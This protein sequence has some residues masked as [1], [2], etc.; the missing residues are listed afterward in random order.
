MD[1]EVGVRHHVRF[2]MLEVVVEAIVV[3]IGQ[4]NLGAARR[5]VALDRKEGDRVGNADGSPG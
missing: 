5:F 3:W 4:E 1:H 2:E